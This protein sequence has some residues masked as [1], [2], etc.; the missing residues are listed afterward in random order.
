MTFDQERWYSGP[1]GQRGI[2][3]LYPQDGAFNSYSFFTLRP[4]EQPSDFG[5]PGSARYPTT[6]LLYPDRYKDS[7]KAN[8]SSWVNA[9][10]IQENYS[11]QGLRNLTVNVGARLELQKLYDF[12]GKP[13]LDATNI[14]PRVGAVLDPF[15]DGRSKLSV[16]YGRYY[17]AI[18]LNVASRYFGGEGILVRNSVPF[19]ECTNP[20]PYNWNGS[21]EWRNCN[22]PPQSATTDNAAGGS[23]LFNNGQNYAVQSNLQGQYHNE[24]VATAEREIIEDMT[25]VSTTSTAGWADHRGRR[26][27]PVADVR[28]RQPG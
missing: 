22:T 3:Q 16:F 21:G 6:D 11:P 14:S 10:F 2:V 8:V 20:D 5:P 13:F 7:L 23:G 12:H 17:E 9:F 24:V 19:S 15:S 26:R 25:V 28:A 18:P 1:L 27:R 4:G